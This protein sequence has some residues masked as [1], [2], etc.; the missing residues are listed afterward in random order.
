[1]PVTRMG[2]APRT[3]P[4][5]RPLSQTICAEQ[6][7]TDERHLLE[8]IVVLAHQSR[9]SVRD[10]YD[11]TYGMIAFSELDSGRWRCVIPMCD[12]ML[13]ATTTTEQPW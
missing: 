7:V 9:L 8:V 13:G 1:M 2:S 4:T 12:D 3:R 5:A 11:G 6:Y 10:V